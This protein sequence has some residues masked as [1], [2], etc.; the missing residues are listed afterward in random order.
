MLFMLRLGQAIAG[1]LISIIGT[2]TTIL[3]LAVVIGWGTYK[4]IRKYPQIF[5][6][7]LII[8]LISVLLTLIPFSG[9]TEEIMFL[10]SGI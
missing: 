3:I 1:Y 10:I 7:L 4:L 6:A 8:L 2:T 5:K 9:Y